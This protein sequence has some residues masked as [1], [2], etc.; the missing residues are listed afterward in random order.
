MS[1][2]RLNLAEGGIAH[3]T[4]YP[5]V[6][7]QI[8]M[9]L[10]VGFRSEADLSNVTISL[11]NDTN[12]D[13]LKVIVDERR[14]LLTSDLTKGT[15]GTPLPAVHQ[16]DQNILLAGN[17][18][19]AR[20]EMQSDCFMVEFTDS[21]VPKSDVGLML[22]YGVGDERIDPRTVQSVTVEGEGVVF[23]QLKYCFMI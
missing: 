15:S 5:L 11:K 4:P 23:N 1:A 3:N 17:A 10:F 16:T 19:I 12:K 14:I 6:N 22:G 20:F 7:F 13:V 9:V 18:M 2:C 21:D 8:G